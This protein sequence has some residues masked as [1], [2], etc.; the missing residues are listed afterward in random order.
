MLMRLRDGVESDLP[1]LIQLAHEML[2]S[3]GFSRFKPNPHKISSLFEFLID[4]EDAL[5]IVA[6]DRDQLSGFFAAEI[7]P[8]LFSDELLAV[9]VAMFASSHSSKNLPIRKISEIYLKWAKHKGASRAIF[10]QSTGV[11]T[12]R[13]SKIFDRLDFQRLGSIHGFDL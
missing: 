5:L 7:V 10:S 2:E 11:N 3:S 13:F 8:L 1:D 6:I 9:D 4:D 12:E